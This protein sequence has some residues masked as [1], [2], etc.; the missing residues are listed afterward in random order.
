MFRYKPILA[1]MLLNSIF[2][3]GSAQNLLDRLR[4]GPANLTRIDDIKVV[5]GTKV[6]RYER[7]TVPLAGIGPVIGGIGAA[8]LL[9]PLLQP[10]PAYVGYSFVGSCPTVRRLLTTFKS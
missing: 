4:P 3:P 2:V 5:S 8:A 6:K 7:M 9:S 1:F 10:Q